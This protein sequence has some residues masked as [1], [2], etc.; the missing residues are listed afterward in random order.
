MRTSHY[1]VTANTIDD[2]WEREAYLAKARCR[3][4]IVRHLI[5]AARVN[6]P[7]PFA[8]AAPEGQ[9]DLPSAPLIPVVRAS[10][11][12]GPKKVQRS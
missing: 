10:M 2:Q 7:Q 8:E 6:T 1:S 12:Y 9:M 4:A 3:A 5:Q 11:V